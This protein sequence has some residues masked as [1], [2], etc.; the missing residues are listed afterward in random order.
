MLGAIMGMMGGTILGGMQG[1]EQGRLQEE[2]QNKQAEL[3]REQAKYSQGLAKEYWDYTNWENQV[4]HLKSAGLNPALMYGGGGTGGQTGGGKAEGVS[5]PEQKQMQIAQNAQA[6]GLQLANLESQIKV[7][8][9]VAEK[10]KAEAE[11]T[12]GVDTEAA[13]MS[14]KL[15]EAQV[16]SERE[17]K[18]VLYWEAEVAESESVLKEALANTEQFNLQKVQ[19][20]IRMVE[21]G[22]EELSE[23]VAM[24]K[25]ENKI[26]DATAE[27]QIEQ[28][29]ANLVD[30]WAG[31][32]LKMAQTETQKE[33]VKAI[34]ERLKQK[35]YE[36]DQKDTE[37]IQRWVDLGI[38][39]VSE[40]GE[41]L[42][43][44]KKL[45]HLAKKLNIGK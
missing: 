11:K 35:D 33:E 17:R 20:D 24:L 7:N 32:M 2:A 43:G 8:E 45:S 1:R 30:T 22:Y 39:G 9:S 29:K 40:V 12:S 42:T 18:N 6:M 16:L 44:I 14:I 38:K 15:S 28:Y 13:R 26:G 10:N 3:N 36:L 41:L 27:M 21:K 5:Q 23:R 31:A 4:N 25:R 19:W 37:I 34:A